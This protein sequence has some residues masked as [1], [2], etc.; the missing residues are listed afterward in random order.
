[1]VALIGFVNSRL[2]LACC[3]ALPDIARKHKFCQGERP[4]PCH[5]LTV[6]DVGDACEHRSTVG[7][8]GLP[9]YSLG[10]YAGQLATQ[11]KAHR[12]EQRVRRDCLRSL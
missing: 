9:Q 11:A 12:C 8:M 2:Q 10:G 4:D 7:P 5:S 6:T 1:M 3:T